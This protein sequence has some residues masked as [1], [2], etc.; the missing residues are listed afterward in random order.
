MAIFRHKK[1]PRQM[2]IWFSVTRLPDPADIKYFGE[3]AKFE[4]SR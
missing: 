4:M 3:H 2:V 1:I